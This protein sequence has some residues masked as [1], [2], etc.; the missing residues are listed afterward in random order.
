M[1]SSY[2]KAFKF[3]AWPST[4]VEKLFQRGDGSDGLRITRF[5]E[6]VKNT[7]QVYSDY[8]GLAGEYEFLF[9]LQEALHA[10]LGCAAGTFDIEHCRVCDHSKI[11]QKI[12][13]KLSDL[14][15]GRMCVMDDINDRLPR[16]D[17][18]WMDACEP[19][20]LDATQASQAFAAME[21]YV[22]ENREQIF[23]M[24]GM[25][26]C[27]MHGQ[28]CPLYPDRTEK[29][30]EPLKKTHLLMSVVLEPSM[31]GWPARRKRMFSCGLSK[32]TMA[33]IGPQNSDDVLKDFLRF[34]EEPVTEDGSV[35]L[36][37]DQK[38]IYDEQ[39]VL[40]RLRGH[41]HTPENVTD[42]GKHQFLA[43]GQLVRLEAYR[44][45]FAAW[46][47]KN[48]TKEVFVDL[49]QNLQGSSTAG[50]WIPSLLT[51]GSIYALKA[52][53]LVTMGELFFS[54]GYN[55]FGFGKG[56]SIR[57][58]RAK[59][60]LKECSIP[61]QMHLLGNGWHLPVV[62]SWFLYCLAHTVRLNRN[63]TVIPEKSLLRKGGSEL[64]EDDDC[65][66]LEI[67]AKRPKN[68]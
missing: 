44:K 46:M 48:P 6:L 11:A 2:Q 59:D 30:A 27:I 22:V 36:L 4:I 17:K 64:K 40:A 49:D 66:V 24:S 3:A 41:V 53:R 43:P 52:D 45:H 31:L 57:T 42:L 62:A 25:G 20:G 28:D 39:R 38:A 56:S 16:L 14:E 67:A 13:C 18:E 35:F 65:D 29:L 68:K 10:K 8:S 61:N 12:L 37:A 23:S 19:Q 63:V 33:W 60:F 51:H 58:C 32:A 26:K 1:D 47:E 54:H 9:Q 55:M 21:K 50:E 15:M 5:N 34:F 7:L